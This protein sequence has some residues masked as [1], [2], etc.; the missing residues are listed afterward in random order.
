MALD[1]QFFDSI[2]IELVKRKFYN[3]NKVNS[4]LSDIQAQALLLSEE[5]IRLK[6][7]LESFRAQK[8]E[9]SEAVLEAK[10]LSREIL[11]KAESEAAEL[12]TKARSEAEETLTSA[13][14]QAEAMVS[15]A[16]E[17]RDELVNERQRQQ[18]LTVE[19]VENCFARLRQQ[20]LEAVDTLNRQW[21]D[22]LVSLYD[23]DEDTQPALPQ[24]LPEDISDKLGNIAQ[25][26]ED[27]SDMEVPAEN[28]E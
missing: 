14:G 3:A 8:A 27:I 25:Q 21:Q 10:K 20:H 13:R 15:D 22:F 7:E 18:E 2:N 17:R 12:L 4:L 23:G 6:A 26:L 1:K 11:S 24:S 16:Q 5:N 19:K 28:K 9:I